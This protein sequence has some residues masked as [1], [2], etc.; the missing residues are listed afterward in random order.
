M[1][2]KLTNSWYK[3]SEKN[4]KHE[5]EGSFSRAP[6]AAE[7]REFYNTVYTA[8]SLPNENVAPYLTQAYLPKL[9]AFQAEILDAPLMK[10]EDISAIARLKS[11]KA[12]GPDG[13]TLYFYK[14]FCQELEPILTEL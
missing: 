1:A 9:T 4:T 5:W 11:Y 8:Q 7:F 6:I 2:I 3:N 12:P 13:Y 14:T 10:E